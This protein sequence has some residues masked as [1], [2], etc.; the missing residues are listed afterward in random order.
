MSGHSKWAS[1][2]HKKAATDAK[3]GKNFTRIIREISV[4]ARADRPEP[5]RAI[6]CPGNMPADNVKRAIMKGPPARGR[7]LRGGHVRRLRA[8]RR[9]HLPQA[10][11][12]NKN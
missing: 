12:D 7:A 3:R 9:G 2:K 6:Q 5:R 10:V 8:R 11:T 1:I 4:A